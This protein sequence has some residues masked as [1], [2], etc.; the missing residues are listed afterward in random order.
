MEHHSNIVPWQM[1][2]EEK[3]AKLRII[4]MNDAGELLMDE[5][6]KLLNPKTKFVSVVYVSNSL[7]TINPVEEII[8]KA[9]A[10]GAVVLIDAAQAM[11]HEQVDVKKL[12]C[13]FLAGS[14]HKMFG[15][16]GVGFLYGKMKYLAAM[17]PYQGGGDMISSVTFEKTTYNEVP[18][19]FEAGTPHIEG[20]IAM[21]CAFDFMNTL[22]L[23]AVQA[24][25]HELVK[26]AS[27]ELSKIERVKLIGTAKNKASVVSFIIEGANAL[28]AGMLLDTMGLAVRTGQHCT[29]PVMD[30]LCIPGTIRASFAVYNT[31]DD[32]KALIEGVKKVVKML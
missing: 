11:A 10:V 27:L 32:T 31:M 6:E 5:Y 7:G 17:P 15:P 21:G 12:D 2:C 26:Y 8:A 18:F 23:E 16:T 9:H 20:V 3:G 28:D 1:L 24:H 29:E 14:A 4:P 19:K 22:D 13:D 30:R 25:E